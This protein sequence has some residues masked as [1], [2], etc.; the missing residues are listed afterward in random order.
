MTEQARER[1]LVINPGSTSTKVAFFQGD[2]ILA[3]AFLPG[4]DLKGKE[5]WEEF[6]VRLEAVRGWLDEEGIKADIQKRRAK[7]FKIFLYFN[8]ALHVPKKDLEAYRKWINRA[9]DGS[10]M[11]KEEPGGSDKVTVTPDFCDESFIA[12]Y[13][14]KAKQLIDYYDPDG[15]AWDMHWGMGIGTTAGPFSWSKPRSG[16]WHGQFRAQYKIYQWL[17][18]AHPQK[19]VLTNNPFGFSPT[20]LVSDANLMEVDITHYPPEFLELQRTYGR[21]TFT[22]IDL[23]WLR[24]QGRDKMEDL[25]EIYVRNILY[26]LGMGISFGA[27]G[28]M[29]VDHPKEAYSFRAPFMDDLQDLYDLSY[30]TSSLPLLS[31]GDFDQAVSLAPAP[32][33]RTTSAWAGEQNFVLAAYHLESLNLP[34]D[35]RVEIV[36]RGAFIRKLRSALLAQNILVPPTGFQVRVFDSRGTSVS[37]DFASEDLPGGDRKFSGH[38]SPGAL[39]VITSQ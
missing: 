38:L 12:Y 18:K 9:P 36:I 37:H 10:Y 32:L 26:G 7:G 35:Q 25:A 15:I 3:E 11:I 28:A 29:F 19:R 14:E 5:I 4:S 6:P 23:P 39:L 21:K 27:Y 2:T 8:Q 1:I 16:F 31:Q 24:S 20:Q 34:G 17:K 33:R 13:V 22:L 30:R